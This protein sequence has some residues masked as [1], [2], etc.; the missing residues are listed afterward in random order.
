MCPAR[1]RTPDWTVPGLI[2]AQ[3][4]R[5]PGGRHGAVLCLILSGGAMSCSRLQAGIRFAA[6]SELTC[7]RIGTLMHF[8]N[9]VSPVHYDGL[10]G[11]VAGSC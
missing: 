2:L 1:L 11:D 9:R 3:D 4:T 5:W 7:N 6:G 8:L 10:P